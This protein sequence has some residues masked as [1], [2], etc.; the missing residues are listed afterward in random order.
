LSEDEVTSLRAVQRKRGS[1][2]EDDKL[3][4]FDVYSGDTSS[5]TQLL[6]AAYDPL[7]ITFL[8]VRSRGQVRLMSLVGELVS[9]YEWN[10]MGVVR[11]NVHEVLWGKAPAGAPLNFQ[12]FA[13]DIGRIPPD[14]KISRNAAIDALGDIPT[15]T[16]IKRM[17]KRLQRATSRADSVR[18]NIAL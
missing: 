1:N 11:A 15:E 4:I 2:P 9:D 16:D 18:R 3:R 7:S 14:G 6:D 13:Q 17:E 12:Q 5:L 10:Q 8:L